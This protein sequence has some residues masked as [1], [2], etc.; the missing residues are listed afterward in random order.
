MSTILAIETSTPRGN[1]ALMVDGRL[2]ADECFVADRGHTSHLFPLLEKILREVVRLDVIVV[3]VG[4]GSYAGIRIGISAA[5][6]IALAHDAKLMGIP[7]V[8]AMSEAS[9]VITIGDARRDSFY[10]AKVEDGFCKEGP[11]LL[12]AVSLKERLAMEGNIPVLA[13]AALPDFNPQIAAPQARLLAGLAGR[14]EYAK[15]ADVLEPL[16]LREAHITPP[17]VPALKRKSPGC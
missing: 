10:F 11:L 4:P 14:V 6:G 2:V 17:K 7:S 9:P 5:T 15:Q 12:D 13:T 1:V 3:G 8:A 16:Y